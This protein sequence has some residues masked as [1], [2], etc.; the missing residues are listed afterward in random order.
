MQKILPPIVIDE[1]DLGLPEENRKF[2]FAYGMNTNKEEMEM[3]CPGAIYI[4][5]YKLKGLRFVFRTVADIDL[6]NKKEDSVTGVVWSITPDC[7]ENLDYLEGYPNLY[8]KIYFSYLNEKIMMYI[9]TRKSKQRKALNSPN[10]DYKRCLLKGYKT[11][12]LPATQIL[13][14]LGETQLSEHERLYLERRST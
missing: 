4:D 11:H 1:S 12:G 14:A 2:Y 5:T 7:E 8:K 13:S 3:R 6:T 9:M 10:D